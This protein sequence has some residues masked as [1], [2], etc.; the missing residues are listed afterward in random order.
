[1]FGWWKA[2]RRKRRLANPFPEEWLQLLPSRCRHYQGLSPDEQQLLRERTQLFIE[3][4]HWEGCN[5][6]TVTAE[7]QITI[8]SH[9]ALMGL[10]FPEVPFERLLSVLIYPDTFVASQPRPTPWGLMDHDEPLLGQIAYQGPVL[11]S[12]REVAR[13]CFEAPA[14]RNVVIHEFAHL[15]DMADHSVDGAPALATPQ[16]TADWA[17]IVP[18]EFRRLQRQSAQGRRTLFDPYGATSQAEFFA[19]TS[20]TFFERP[21][22]MAEQHPRLYRLYRDYYRQDPTARME[23][24]SVER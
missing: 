12:W 15:L 24:L 4:K 8:A 5:G 6:V 14:G 1:M 23:S 13:D 17:D 18:V 19:V 2:W 9:A 11:L 7:M 3:E 22:Q 10:G 20:E 16:Q 21:R